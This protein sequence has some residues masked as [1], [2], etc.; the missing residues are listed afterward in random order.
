MAFESR[1]ALTDRLGQ[2][3]GTGDH[4]FVKIGDVA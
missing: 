2:S 4:D 1:G 3:L